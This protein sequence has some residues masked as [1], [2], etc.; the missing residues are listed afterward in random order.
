MWM[1]MKYNRFFIPE[2]ED[3]KLLNT[4]K[5][6]SGKNHLGDEFD[7]F[8]RYQVNKHWQLT[9]ALGKFIPG[10]LMPINNQPA[11]RATWFSIQVLY[12]I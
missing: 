12:S 4:M 10:D 9:G 1:E 5:L 11:K 3:F 2:T 6:Q 7:L 8:I